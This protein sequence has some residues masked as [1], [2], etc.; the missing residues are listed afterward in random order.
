MIHKMMIAGLVLAALSLPALAATQYYI[1]K[2]VATKK[3]T[4][5]DK[6]PD[7]KTAMMVGKAAYVSKADADAAM[8]KAADCKQ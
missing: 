3:C 7:G 6:K 2:D 1:A 5:V 8:K 4:V